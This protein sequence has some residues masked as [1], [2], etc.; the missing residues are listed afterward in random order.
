MPS[1][2]R[3]VILIGFAFVIAVFH[4]QKYRKEKVTYTKSNVKSGGSCCTTGK[5]A[6]WLLQNFL[7]I[8][9]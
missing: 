3:V 7:Q 6:N 2:P 4:K 8:Y 1:T 9:I 5:L